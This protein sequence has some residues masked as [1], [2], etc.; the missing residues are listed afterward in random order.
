MRNI[1]LIQ[2]YKIFMML[3][4]DKPELIHRYFRHHGIAITDQERNQL[5]LNFKKE[6]ENA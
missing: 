6:R 4:K 5:E 1:A 2:V 3:F